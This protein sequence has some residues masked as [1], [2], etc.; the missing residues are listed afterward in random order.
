MG[1]FL[2]FT[3]II[4]GTGYKKNMTKEVPLKT[5]ILGSNLLLKQICRYTF[6][7]RIY[8]YIVRKKAS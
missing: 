4:L 2:I 3:F 5:E 1:M 6:R 8:I 7:L